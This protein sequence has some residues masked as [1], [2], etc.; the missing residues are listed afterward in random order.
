MMPLLIVCFSI[1]LKSASEESSSIASFIMEF[2][3]LDHDSLCKI[4]PDLCLRKTHIDSQ[5]AVYHSYEYH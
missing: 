3:F 2:Q 1:L 5:I 4:D